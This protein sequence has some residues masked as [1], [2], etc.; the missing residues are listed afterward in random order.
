MAE[1]DDEDLQQLYTWIDE[2]PLSRPKKNIARDFSDGVL[3]AE[4]VK[5]FL[6][7]MV[8]LHNYT[9][10]NSITQ[11]IGNW[12]TLNRKVFAKLSFTV[13]E[14]VIKGAVNSRPG[15]IEFVL[16]NLRVKIQKHMSR[17]QNEK[18]M[19]KS[20]DDGHVTDMFNGDSDIL[21]S[22][23]I[24]MMGTGAYSMVPSLISKH[25]DSGAVR[26]PP[27]GS[28]IRYHPTPQNYLSVTGHIPRRSTVPEADGRYVQS[29]EIRVQSLINRFPHVD[30][31]I[32]IQEKEQQLLE[33]QETIQIL[34]VKVRR[35]EHLLRLKD[36]R[37]EELAKRLQLSTLHPPT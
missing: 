18:S 3:T 8:D 37:I 32:A 4:V 25:T 14:N 11:K 33:A 34:Q 22:N 1:M 10:A 30:P 15:V 20:L 9:P 21:Y 36:M 19:P 7:K 6:P 31:R 26:V 27:N 24:D 28:T 2:I 16:N 29:D 13:P 23:S 35:M 5:H 12:T 17:K